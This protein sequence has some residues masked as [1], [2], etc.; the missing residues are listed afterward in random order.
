M[1]GLEEEEAE[2]A[3]VFCDEEWMGVGCRIS[4]LGHDEA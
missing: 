2:R 4:E 3:V 1:E